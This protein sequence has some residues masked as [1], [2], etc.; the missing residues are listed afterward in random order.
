[1]RTLSLVFLITCSYTDI[2]EHRINRVM[3]V[4][5]L[6]FSVILMVCVHF[7]GERFAV[8]DRLLFYKP[9][10]LSITCA[11]IPGLILLVISIIS[12]EAVG[13]GDVYVVAVLGLMLGFDRTFF[14]LFGRT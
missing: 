11:F 1:M 4:L 2:K 9:D 6:T 10:R 3:P 14:I 7:L 12:R 13:R 8:L 5:F